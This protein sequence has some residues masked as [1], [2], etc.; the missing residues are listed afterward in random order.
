MIPIT[1]MA[2][3]ASANTMFEIRIEAPAMLAAAHIMTSKTSTLVRNI[4]MT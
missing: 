2:T 4:L 1:I 3:N